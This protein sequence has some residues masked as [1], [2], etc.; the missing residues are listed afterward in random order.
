MTSVAISRRISAAISQRHVEPVPS[1][2]L[3]VRRS[4]LLAA[5]ICAIRFVRSRPAFRGRRRRATHRVR[6]LGHSAAVVPTLPPEARL[7]LIRHACSRRASR[8]AIDIFA[9]SIRSIIDVV[10][11]SM[12]LPSA[13]PTCLCP[14]DSG[15][16][17][18]E[19][20]A[21]AG[22]RSPRVTAHPPV[23]RQ[24]AEARSAPNPAS[25][26]LVGSA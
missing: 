24:N 20:P 14:I 7:E 1:L 6:T 2:R 4:I 17:R 11:A 22:T 5:A 12:A 16:R 3:F 23:A 26:G 25:V 8:Q 21:I 9:I 19:E 15:R 10:G 13:A 18:M